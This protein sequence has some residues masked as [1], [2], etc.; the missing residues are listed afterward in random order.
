MK[1]KKVV[2]FVLIIF[3][4]FLLGF[5]LMKKFGSGKDIEV[6]SLNG[7]KVNVLDGDILTYNSAVTIACDNCFVD[8]KEVSNSKKLT[9]SKKYKIKV[10]DIKFYLEIDK[11]I[12]FKIKDYFGNEIH[13]YLT[14]KLPF[15]IESSEDIKLDDKKYEKKVFMRLV[16]IKLNQI[17]QKKR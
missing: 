16:V 10:K 17:K 14:N 11:D 7:E 3:L 5:L 8:S 4:I 9:E 1:N 15:I 13:N 6:I 2:V 12:D